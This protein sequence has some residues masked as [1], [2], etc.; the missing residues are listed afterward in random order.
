MTNEEKTMSD[1]TRMTEDQRCRDE[2]PPS[3]PSRSPVTC[4]G[5]LA[6]Y[7]VKLWTMMELEKI[8]RELVGSQSRRPTT[9]V[10]G[11]GER[12]LW[13]PTTPWMDGVGGKMRMAVGT[14]ERSFRRPPD[15]V[16]AGSKG[17]VGK[18]G[19]RQEQAPVGMDELGFRGPPDPAK[20]RT[21]VVLTRKSGAPGTSMLGFWTPP[22]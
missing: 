3:P 21:R 6:S 19:D 8:T 16:G 2:G 9:A 14:D 1:E 5:L 18:G 10:A 7:G 13:Q 11:T 12:C 4:A 15:P 22:R 17:C 20:V